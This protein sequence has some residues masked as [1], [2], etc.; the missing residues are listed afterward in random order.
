MQ[1]EQEKPIFIMQRKKGIIIVLYYIFAILWDLATAFICIIFMTLDN[2]IP[3]IMG[4]LILVFIPYQFFCVFDIKEVVCYEDYLLLKRKFF[5][6]KIFYN[7][8]KYYCFM[9]AV[10]TKTLGLRFKKYRL[11]VAINEYML[12][13]SDIQEFVKILESKKISKYSLF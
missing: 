8:L 7:H 12:K 6:K 9:R 11:T 13:P 3:N 10:R 2:I 5:T 4:F 1:V